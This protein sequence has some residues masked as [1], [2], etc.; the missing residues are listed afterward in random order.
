MAEILSQSE[1]SNLE[2]LLNIGQYKDY[3]IGLSDLAYEGKFEWQHSITPLG[4]YNDWSEGN[5]D[6]HQGNEDCV[7]ITGQYGWRWDDFVC[8]N[9]FFDTQ[10]IHALCQY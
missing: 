1:Q 6:N 4:E 7:H 2:A 10:E 8:D 9:N 3:W 5:P